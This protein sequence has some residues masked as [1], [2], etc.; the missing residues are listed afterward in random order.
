VVFEA[1]AGASVYASLGI[2]IVPVLSQ[3]TPVPFVYTV[4]LNYFFASIVNGTTQVINPGGFK[5][6]S[7]TLDRSLEYWGLNEVIGCDLTLYGND[8]R[9][10]AAILFADPTRIIKILIEVKN[11]ADVNFT[12]LTTSIIDLNSIAFSEDPLIY[13]VTFGLLKSSEWTQLMSYKD[14]EVSLGSVYD[15][16]GK[17]VTD[18]TGCLDA[19]FRE[20]NPDTY[21]QFIQLFDGKPVQMNAAQVKGRSELNIGFAGTTFRNDDYAAQETLNSA[22]PTLIPNHGFLVGMSFEMLLNFTVSN[23]NVKVEYYTGNNWVPILPNSVVP[24]VL[25]I[26]PI[27]NTLAGGFF[28][29]VVNNTTNDETIT[30]VESL[31]YLKFRGTVQYNQTSSPIALMVHPYMALKGFTDRLMGP[32]NNLSAPPLVAA[33][34]GQTIDFDPVLQDGFSPIVNPPPVS[35]QVYQLTPV[36]KSYVPKGNIIPSDSVRV[37]W[38]WNG[39]SLQVTLGGG[40]S[41]AYWASS[42][43]A[44]NTANASYTAPMAPGVMWFAFNAAAG[45]GMTFNLYGMT[46]EAMDLL[47][48]QPI[49]AG[50]NSVYFTTTKFYQQFA[51][52]VT[53]V[54][55]ASI[56]GVALQYDPNPLTVQPTGKY[57]LN[58]LGAGDLTQDNIASYQEIPFRHPP[59][60]TSLSKVLSGLCRILG[61][62]AYETI[63]PTGKSILTIDE[64]STVFQNTL[65]TIS[66]KFEK[67]GATFDPELTYDSVRVGGPERKKFIFDSDGSCE[68][69]TYSSE[70]S[71]TGKEKDFTSPVILDPLII[72]GGEMGQADI[73]MINMS[74][75]RTLAN[76]SGNQVRVAKDLTIAN[77]VSPN[78]INWVHSEARIVRRNEPILFANGT[79]LLRITSASVGNSAR[80]NFALDTFGAVADSDLVIGKGAFTS[81]LLEF[82]TGLTLD[83]YKTVILDKYKLFPITIG[84]KSGQGRIKQLVYNFASGRALLKI[85]FKE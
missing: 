74:S 3:T 9:A 59:L 71:T 43:R 21:I 84:S 70:F 10:L 28:V 72:L 52:E 42:P 85:W 61:L 40:Q 81:L 82:E 8:A 55:N 80:V 25:T 22:E 51:I 64:L 23:N 78:Q 60:F 33:F 75:A 49:V 20:Q 69:T 29:R 36:I 2:R 15:V 50:P 57:S 68:E 54:G 47:A 12:I 1:E 53:G 18:L 65:S 5:T 38:T 66:F 11:P 14:T 48:S 7:A 63:N 24:I 83:E 26:P 44:R 13:S 35:A 76:L 79:R 19:V 67:S 34:I 41:S 73:F 30:I 6:L 27:V 32:Y 37:P 77:S 45:A 56:S 4:S 58:Y 31:S 16:V 39:A 62:A 17:D 46:G